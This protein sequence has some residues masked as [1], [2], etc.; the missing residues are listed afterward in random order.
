MEGN[1]KTPKSN[2]IGE[3]EFANKEY[4]LELENLRNID[5]NYATKPLETSFNWNE[6]ATGIKD[7][8]GEWYLVAFRSIRSVNNNNDL[9]IEAE[10]Q[11]HYEAKNHG[12]LLKYWSG[13][14]NQ[15]RECLSMCIWASRDNAVEASKK[16]SHKVA[17]ELTNENYETYTL[18]RYEMKKIKGETMISIIPIIENTNK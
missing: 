17:K 1:L 7:V 10:E 6:I 13:K 5:P 2:K 16:H 8:E 3:K 18:E 9:L 15:S 11:A 12:G 4:S 14:F